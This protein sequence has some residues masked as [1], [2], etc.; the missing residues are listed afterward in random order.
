M[1][2]THFFVFV[3]IAF[4]SPINAQ[5]GLNFDV[6][7]GPRCIIHILDKFNIASEHSL[8]DLVRAFHKPE[9]V[10]AGVSL[11]AISDYLH[12]AG[13]KTKA[14]KQ[15]PLHAFGD[16]PVYLIHVLKENGAGHFIVLEKKNG[17]SLYWDGLNGYSAH[18]PRRCN[19]TGFVLAVSSVEITNPTRVST[20][21]VFFCFGLFG[22]F[23]LLICCRRY[24]LFTERT[25]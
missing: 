7:C 19:A 22:V 5:E 2:K 8:V 1:V 4:V 25:R 15:G 13:L 18:F 24:F 6:A 12:S 9:T 10:D 21:P 20:W 16:A 11:L 14:F 17:K 3:C 23:S